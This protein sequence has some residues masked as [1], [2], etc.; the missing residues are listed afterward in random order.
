MRSAATSRDHVPGPHDAHVGS[1]TGSRHATPARSRLAVARRSDEASDEGG[2]REVRRI[3]PNGR[4]LGFMASKRT[5]AGRA[6]FHPV[7]LITS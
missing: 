6:Y 2:W 7:T 5:P 4:L 1:A 3:K